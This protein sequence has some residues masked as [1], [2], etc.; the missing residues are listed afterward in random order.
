[1]GWSFASPKA[2]LEGLVF[3]RVVYDNIVW[4]TT[5]N[6]NDIALTDTSTTMPE[7]LYVTLFPG[8]EIRGKVVIAE[9]LSLEASYTLLYSFLLNDG[10]TSLTLADNRRV[11]YSPLHSLSAR[12]RYSG[13]RLELGVE[14]RY[15]SE[16]YTDTTNSG[17]SALPGYFLA[18]ADLRFNLGENLAFTLA[19]RNILN[20]VYFTQSGYPMPPFSIQTGVSVKL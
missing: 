12:A 4:L 18:N 20:T 1:V 7:N 15:V 17:S 14:L 8:A 5:D 2:S 9:Q 6:R 3:T 16:E 10:T 13:K 19:G 11:P